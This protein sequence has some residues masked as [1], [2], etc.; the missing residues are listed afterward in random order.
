LHSGYWQHLTTTDL[1]AVDPEHT[2]ALLPV[3]AIEQHGPHLP[4]GTD[5]LIAAGIVRATLERQ[6]PDGPV[7]LALPALTLGHSPEHAAFAGTLSASATALMELWVDVGRG[8]ARSG[9]RKL[10]LLNTHGGQKPLVDLVAVRLRA[11]L[12]LLV[13][14]ASYF[15][16]GVPPGLFDASEIAHDIHGGVLETSLMLHL[17][18]DLVRQGELRDFPGLPQELAARHSLL[19][20]EKPVGIGWLSQDLDR[21]GA[22][23][24]AD[25]ADAERGAAYLA[26]LAER[27]DTLVGEVAA[28]PLS[29]LK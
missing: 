24:H 2:V 4:L 16:F 18:S 5:A 28:T 19:G 3:S 11:E 14:R 13:V 25:R 23:G 8:V 22:C 26:F 29:I 17:H 1:A 12:G 7:L 10:I 6:R 20:A 27:L 9:V 15:S 21:T